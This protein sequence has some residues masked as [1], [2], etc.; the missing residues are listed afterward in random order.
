[1]ANAKYRVL[2]GK[3]FTSL[4]SIFFSSSRFLT[5]VP[6]YISAIQ[7]NKSLLFLFSVFFLQLQKANGQQLLDSLSLSQQKVYRSFSEGLQQPDSV[8]KLDLSKQKRKE[9]PVEIR[10]FKNLQVLKLQR[11]NLKIIPEWISDFR[12]LQYLDLSNNKLEA[13]PDSIGKLENLKYLGLNRNL[14]V[15][16]PASVGNL[17]N[18]EILEMWDNEVDSLPDEIKFLNNLKILELRG[19]LFSE[20]EQQHIKSL[21]PEADVY[22]SPSCNC[23]N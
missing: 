1:M 15:T 3:L 17:V 5:V 20:P 23:K 18:L 9:V 16:L 11:N 22:F 14:I 6:P 2:T 12:N 13:L 4:V 8:F 7:M 21:L 19:I 10:K